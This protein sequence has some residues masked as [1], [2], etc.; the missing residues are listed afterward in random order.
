MA[1]PK[2]QTL[3]QKLGFFD[4]DLKKPKHDD[5]MLWLD[6]NI[7]DI[8]N[9]YCNPFSNQK[10]LQYFLNE[11]K[12]LFNKFNQKGKNIDTSFL[13]KPVEV[14]RITRISKKWEYAIENQNFRG[15]NV[16]GF[17][18]FYASF[19]YPVPT[20]PGIGYTHSERNNEIIDIRVPDDLIIDFDAFRGEMLI[21]VK[22][23]IKSLGE[24]M[25]QINLYKSYRKG[26]YFV[27]CPDA[28]HQKLLESQGV[29]FILFPGR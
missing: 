2:A 7:E 6:E 10:R 17:V 26:R 21:E 8:V 20:I 3:Q 5:M 1:K 18:D 12:E 9:T 14:P 15:H 22:T 11:K 25:R 13:D 4:E 19:N 29:E 28:T 16:I 24:L 27:L 23:E